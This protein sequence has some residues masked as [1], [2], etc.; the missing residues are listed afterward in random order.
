MNFTDF[1]IIV[2]V[3]IFVTIIWWGDS[4]EFRD[5]RRLDYAVV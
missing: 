5:I 3:L 1:E 4:T 2:L